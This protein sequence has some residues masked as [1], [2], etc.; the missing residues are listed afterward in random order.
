MEAPLHLLYLTAGSKDG[1]RVSAPRLY[2]QCGANSK[3]EIV[4][5]FMSLKADSSS[6]LSIPVC[7]IELQEHAELDHHYVQL[8][9]KDAMHMKMT[10]IE[11]SSKSG[12][13]LVESSIG[14]LL[15]RHDLYIYQVRIRSKSV[16]K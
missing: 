14:G 8:D 10:F 11:Q 1:V 16:R 12:Y 2:I 6:H 3:A 9:G 13:R 15:S 4:E 5:E 7:E